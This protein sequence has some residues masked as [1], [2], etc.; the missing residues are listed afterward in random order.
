MT[1]IAANNSDRFLTYR[2]WFD[3][4][5]GV[6]P[7]IITGFERREDG[8]WDRFDEEHVEIAF[9]IDDL[10]SM[11]ES[12]GFNR[13]QVIDWREGEITELAPGTEDSFRVLF[14]ARRPTV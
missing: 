12:A 2:S 10:H 8:A 6:S 13:V 4:R 7:L 14:M 9:A 3:E 5:H 1:L 11:L